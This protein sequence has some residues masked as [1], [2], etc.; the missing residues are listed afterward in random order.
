MSSNVESKGERSVAIEGG[1]SGSTIHTGDEYFQAAPP[2]R[3]ANPPFAVPYTEHNPDFAGRDA[4]LAQLA[5]WLRAGQ[6][7]VVAG[8]GGVG[9]TQLAL[10]LTLQAKDAP[11]PQPYPGGI[12]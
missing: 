7:A 3:Y 9:K 10:E 8:A 6:T 4:E 2:P 5:A 1:V 12:F 11:D